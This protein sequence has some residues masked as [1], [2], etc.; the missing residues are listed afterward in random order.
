M[1]GAPGRTTGTVF[2]MDA[3]G[4][5]TTLHTFESLSR[6][7]PIVFDGTPMSN[8]FEGADGSLYGTTFNMPRTSFVT[9]PGQIFKI[10]PT[11]DFTTVS[12]AYWLRAGVIQARDGRLYGTSSGG[13][14][15]T[16]ITLF[17]YVFRVEADGTAAQ[18]STDSTAPTA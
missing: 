7:R 4:A 6:R 5:R 2:A 18:F 8:L 3:A 16:G 15:R 10:S 14:R 11:G 12:S 9:R 13:V 17:G 1:S